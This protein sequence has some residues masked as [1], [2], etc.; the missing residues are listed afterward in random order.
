VTGVT[1]MWMEEG[2]DTG[3]M[4][5]VAQ[6]PIAPDD[7]ASTLGPRLAELG[8]QL[9]VKTLTSLRDGELKA[10]PQPELGVSH[11]P[12]LTKDDGRLRWQASAQA[13]RDRIRGVSPWPGAWCPWGER[14]LKV[15]E[16]EV[17]LDGSG[18]EPG[19]V[20]SVDDGIVV[21]CGEGALRL[22]RVQPPNK[23]PMSADAFLRGYA[24]AV[25]DRLQES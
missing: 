22:T 24:L 14:V 10:T 5:Q 2:L 15:H 1:T 7:T 18:A 9:L 13:N 4:L 25:G 8:A 12:L 6:E 21:A 16:A 3:P 11:A 23:R 19:T 20:I 17:A